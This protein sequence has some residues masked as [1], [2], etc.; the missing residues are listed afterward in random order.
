MINAGGMQ[1]HKQERQV[2]TMENLNGVTVEQM[3]ET[4]AQFGIGLAVD[5]MKEGYKVTRAG[6]NGKGMFAAYQKGYPDGIPCNAQTAK[7][8]GMNEGDLFKCRPYLQLRCADG[9]HAMWTPSTSDV[10]AEDWMI[11]E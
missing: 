6:W 8:W 3:I 4:K 10:L 11:V 1:T 5:L 7:T 9:T 2:K